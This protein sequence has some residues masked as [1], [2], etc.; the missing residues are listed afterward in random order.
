MDYKKLTDEQIWKLISM[1]D[2]TA[3]GFV[4]KTFVKE[5]FKYG[6]KFTKDKALIEDVI[7]D[8]F[9]SLWKSKEK[10]K[11]EKSIKF[12]LIT[13]FRRELIRRISAERKFDTIEDCADTYFIEHSYIDLLVQHQSSIQMNEDLTHALSQL[14]A[15]QRE[16]IYLKYFVELS[17]EE[18]AETLDMQV[19]SL[20]NL[21]MKAMK[22]L[23]LSM[24]NEKLLVNLK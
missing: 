22:A 24:K 6:C 18:I 17:Y 10:V 2:R 8:T 14:T 19:P 23:K 5:F 9:V 15:R 16:A 3:F 1:G 11:I 21:I 13:A 7:Q 12:Y 20:Y 4:F